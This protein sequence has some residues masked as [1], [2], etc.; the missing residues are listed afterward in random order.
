VRIDV[1]D[2]GSNTFHLLEAEVVGNS[3]LPVADRKLPVRIGDQA[4]TLG[5][6]PAEA[7]QRG[8]TAIDSLIAPL[9]W[10][11]PVAVATG[12]FREASNG[13]AFLA[14]ACAR[15]GFETRLLTGEEEARLV[16]DGVRAEAMEPGAR[17]AVF[18]LG[19]GSLECV[20]GEGGHI[21]LAESLPLGVLRLR[22]AKREDVH[23]RVHDVAGELI[24]AIR[25]SEPDEIVLA[26]GTARALL[27][28]SRRLGRRDAV[29]GCIARGSLRAI[30]ELLCGCTPEELAELGIP[31]ARH[32]TIATGALVLSTLVERLGVPL[33]RVAAG[34][35]REGVV[36]HEAALRA[37]KVA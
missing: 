11:R 26:A 28:L 29:V 27:K 23:R 34:A 8:M 14:E 24:D 33:V 21:E 5:V 31:A 1:L 19:G 2:L 37:R 35:L 17:L 15:F 7:W 10:R 30:A 6:I 32:D 36:L 13:A 25:A 18:D 9:R 22:A 3:V 20:V 4:F 16:Y 12:V